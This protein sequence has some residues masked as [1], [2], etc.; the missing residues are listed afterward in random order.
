MHVHKTPFLSTDPTLRRLSL[1]R[2]G[3]L[4]KVAG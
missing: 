1:T 2:V 4:R 3:R